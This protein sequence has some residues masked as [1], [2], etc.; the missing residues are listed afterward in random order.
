MLHWARNS[1]KGWPV[2]V[3]RLVRP[4]RCASSAVSWSSHC[5]VPSCCA[6]MSWNNETGRVLFNQ[7][8]VARNAD[9]TGMHS[10]SHDELWATFPNKSQSVQVEGSGSGQIFSVTLLYTFSGYPRGCQNI[11]KPWKMFVSEECISGK[12]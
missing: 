1:Y 2:E 5:F 11:C 4:L 6:T 12:L 8:R 3:H 9:C 10:G 7:T